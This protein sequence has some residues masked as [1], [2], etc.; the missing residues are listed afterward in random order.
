MPE[1]LEK[2]EVTYKYTAHTIDDLI[3]IVKRRSKFGKIRLIE[4]KPIEGTE[5][6]DVKIVVEEPELE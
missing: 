1:K 4:A 6:L 3:N 2:K 5:Q